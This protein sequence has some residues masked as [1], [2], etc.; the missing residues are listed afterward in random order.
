MAYGIQVNTLDG[1]VDITSLISAQL[2]YETVQSSSSGSAF[3]GAGVTA[4][5][6]VGVCLPRDGK[7]PVGEVSVTNNTVSWTQGFFPASS[8]TSNFTLR[9][10]R[11]Y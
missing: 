8:I 6:S 3:V 2:V 7:I 4:S 5:N 1:F 11:I 10:Y 9:V